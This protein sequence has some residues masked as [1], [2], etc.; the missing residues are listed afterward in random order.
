MS[1]FTTIRE[2]N[3][4]YNKCKK[5]IEA[6]SFVFR[7]SKG[8]H[9]SLPKKNTRNSKR[10]NFEDIMGER[11]LVKNIKKKKMNTLKTFVVML[12]TKASKYRLKLLLLVFF[13]LRLE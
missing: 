7:Q 13:S 6:T 9:P 3:A 2:G 12:K 11:I 8:M 4:F 5:I 1:I 10:L